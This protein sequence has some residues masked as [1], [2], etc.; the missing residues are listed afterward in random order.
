VRREGTD[1]HDQARPT[2]PRAAVDGG[3]DLLLI[4]RTVTQA[5]DPVAAAEALVAELS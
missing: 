3:A 2:T 5:E 1:V 4:G